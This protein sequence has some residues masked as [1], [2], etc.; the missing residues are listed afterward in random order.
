M[1]K[2]VRHF[3]LII[4]LTLM[5]SSFCNASNEI[6]IATVQ[7]TINPM[8]AEYL[9]DVIAR[10]ND[11]RI[12]AVIIEL[13]TPGGLV[14]STRM[15]VQNQMNSHVPIITYVSPQGAR[16]ASAGMFIT[17]A[18]HIAAMSP[19]TNIGAAHP[20]NMGPGG[21]IGEEEDEDD[22]AEEF[23][24]KTEISC[25]ISKVSD[26]SVMEDKILNDMLAW[27]RTIAENRKRNV[28]WVLDSVEHSISSTESEALEAGVIDLICK[29][30]SDLLKQLDGMEIII[31]DST[32]V[33]NTTDAQVIEKP[34]TVRQKYLSILINPTLAIYL[35]VLGALG[36]YVE[37]THPGIILP[38]VV[39]GICFILGLFAMHTLPI[40]FAGLLLI[41][42]A[43]IFFVLEVKVHSYGILS[44]G[45]LTAFILGS[46]MLVD[47]EVSGM[48][49][50]MI[51]IIPLAV[52]AAFITIVL[53]SLVLKS[54]NRSVTTGQTGMIGETGT[55][56]RTVNPA[57]QAFIHGEIWSVRSQDDS[58]I[59]VNKK[60]I[61]VESSSLT[62][63]VKEVKS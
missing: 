37:L 30:R 27:S 47:T 23:P 25:R 20:V 56:T 45:G 2:T 38:G 57:G 50:S 17:I 14:E 48:K 26:K 52:S 5:L 60:V 63:V 24:E 34:M 4:F 41:L 1:A 59:S 61:V 31:D 16:A 8:V 44:I 54:H 15:I 58:E 53:V 49:V 46:S 19:A 43:F 13:D 6:W 9:G 42:L 39:G 3:Y 21:P 29:D 10:A 55:V 11:A 62:L 28:E 51:S 36:I 33:L 22:S 35:L 7:D 18:S 12:E 40:N 32:V